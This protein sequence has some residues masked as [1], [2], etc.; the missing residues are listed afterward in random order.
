MMAGGLASVRI[1]SRRAWRITCDYLL[2]FFARHLDGAQS[3]LLEHPSAAYPEVLAG[4]PK[5][6]LAATLPPE[7]T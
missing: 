6:L 4:S 1:D 5:A 2:A 7:A 3:R